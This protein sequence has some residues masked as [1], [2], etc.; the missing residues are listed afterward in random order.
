M[1]SLDTVPYEVFGKGKVVIYFFI[2]RLNPP[3]AGHEVALK[4]LIQMA[5]EDRSIPLILVGS[6][7]NKGERTLNDPLTFS[8]KKRVLIHRLAG[9]LCEIRE[10][11]EPIR[12]VIEWTQEVLRNLSSTPSEVVFKLVTGDKD[13]NSTKLDWVHK[14]IVKR[15]ESL[16]LSASSSTVAIK[17]VKMSGVEMSATKVRQ[18]ALISLMRGDHS[19]EAKYG[20]YYGPQTVNVCGEINEIAEQMGSNA[21][22][23]YAATGE[24]PKK[25]RKKKGNVNKGNA[26]NANSKNANSKNSKTAK[27][28]SKS[29]AKKK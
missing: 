11:T 1:A 6:G 26:N 15:A 25:T 27:S 12:D 21:V 23:V 14:S 4:Q 22:E 19:F 28:K 13:D 17:A 7:P 3:H 20:D 24:L 10:K 2:G 8:T 9:H 18:D 16:G 5:S 29:A